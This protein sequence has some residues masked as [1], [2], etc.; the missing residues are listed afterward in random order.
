MRCVHDE[1]AFFPISFPILLSQRIARAR[2]IIGMI[3]RHLAIRAHIHHDAAAGALVPT[4]PLVRP[5]AP[6]KASRA[7]ALHRGQLPVASADWSL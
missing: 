7:H 1:G 6:S 5:S 2:P 4:P 3:C